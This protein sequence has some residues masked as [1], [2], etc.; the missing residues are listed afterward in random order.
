M[1]WGLPWPGAERAAQAESAGASAFCAG[2]FSDL[3]AYVTSTEMVGRSFILMSSSRTQ[4]QDGIRHPSRPTT[5]RAA[6]D[7]A[8]STQESRIS[9][10][11]V[12][13]AP[14]IC[15]SRASTDGA[16]PMREFDLAL[17]THTVRS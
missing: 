9:R 4:Q 13:L 1:K 15:A 12:Q 8:I 6:R 2:E 3:S 11:S 10:R 14:R 16:G 17:Q 5:T 7:I